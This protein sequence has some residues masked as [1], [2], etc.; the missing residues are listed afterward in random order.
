MTDGEHINYYETGE[1]L[2][3]CWCLDGNRHGESIIYFKTGEIESKCYYI[4][5]NLITELEWLGYN[6]N[7]KLE[8]LGL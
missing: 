5:D 8:L 1:I 7:L 4:N 3:K 2:S 6:R